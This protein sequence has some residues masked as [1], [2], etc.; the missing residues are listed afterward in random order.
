MTRLLLTIVLLAGCQR[1]ASWPPVPVSVALGED[2]CASCRMIT[3]DVHFGAQLH[4]RAGGVQNFD[5][6]GCW[7]KAVAGTHPDPVASFV[8]SYSDGAWIRIDQSFV[9][10]FAELHTPMGSGLAAF[11]TRGAATAFAERHPGAAVLSSTEVI[12]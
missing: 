12:Q 11:P 7:Q 8:R 3:S 4:D 9:V 2:A 1:D 6:L 5:D 10:R